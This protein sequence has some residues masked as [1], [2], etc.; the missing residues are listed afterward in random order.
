MGD[1]ISDTHV[2][3]DDL[4]DISHRTFGDSA[5]FGPDLSFTPIG[6]GSGFMSRIVVVDPDWK[7]PAPKFAPRNF[8]AKISS[9][10][11]I[12]ANF[13][14]MDVSKFEG[15]DNE[16][17][18]E[19]L[20][21]F[22][23]N[24]KKLHNNE[25]IIY[26]WFYKHKIDIP[27]LQVYYSKSFSQHNVNKGLLLM[28]YK[29]DATSLHVWDNF[30]P[31][32][33]LPILRAKAKLEAWADNFPEEEKAKL[34]MNPFIDFYPQILNEK[35]VSMN[36]GVTEKFVNDEIKELIN[37]T[38]DLGS[39]IYDFTFADGI[40]KR[41]GMKPTFIH[42]DLWPTNMLMK[43]RNDGGYDLEALIDFQ[44]AH[45]GNPA[46]DLAR[47]FINTLS[48]K[49]RREHWESLT[50]AFYGYLKEEFGDKEL[51]YTLEQC[52]ESYR[53][54]MPTGGLLTIPMFGGL[55]AMVVYGDGPEEFKK[56]VDS[57]T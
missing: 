44:T 48:G 31:N 12:V 49:D 40:N 6:E 30:A 47:L 4:Q 35:N 54:Y 45:W 39:A 52:K 17:G 7:E 1:G 37:K 21:A 55:F 8:I 19:M 5:N 23:G 10:A 25:V 57:F 42:G 53:Q 43:K 34:K 24:L 11:G 46:T 27:K 26:D 22:E 38:K 28:E 2:T 50:E 51:P 41:L 20:H 16:T 29:P 33:L 32:D 14:K 18:S 56:H 9:M 15:I 13:S 36:F 3:V